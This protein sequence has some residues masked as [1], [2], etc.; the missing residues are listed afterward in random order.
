MD[1]CPNTCVCHSKNQFCDDLVEY[2]LRPLVEEDTK[3]TTSKFKTKTPLEFVEA[4]IKCAKTDSKVDETHLSR[5]AYSISQKHSM[6]MFATTP[7]G[8]KVKRSAKASTLKV[9]K[10]FKKPHPLI[11]NRV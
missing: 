7:A 9:R 11:R 1:S 2:L 10:S 5:R 4:A 6:R 8:N 3:I